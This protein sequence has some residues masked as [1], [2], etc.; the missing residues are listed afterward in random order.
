V[1]GRSIYFPAGDLKALEDTLHRALRVAQTEVTLC[2][3]SNPIYESLEHSEAILRR[4]LQRVRKA[5]R[6]L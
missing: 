3:P 5:R 2:H 4:N 1:K 6:S